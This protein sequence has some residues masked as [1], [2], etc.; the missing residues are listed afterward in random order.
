MLHTSFVEI[1]SLVPEKKILKVFTIYGHDGQLG[2]VT[3]IILIHFHLLLNQM[4]RIYFRPPY[5]KRLYTKFVM[6]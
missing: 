6:D 1:D 2:H 4:R 3:S 5:T